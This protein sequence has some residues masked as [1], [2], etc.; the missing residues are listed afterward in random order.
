MNIIGVIIYR[1]SSVISFLIK[2]CSTCNTRDIEF[3]YTVRSP[4]ERAILEQS[5]ESIYSPKDNT[6]ILCL[7]IYKNNNY[8]CYFNV[9]VQIMQLDIIF[10][11]FIRKHEYDIK[12]QPVSYTIKNIFEKLTNK[13]VVDFKENVEFLSKVPRLSQLIKLDTGGSITKCYKKLMDIIQEENFQPEKVDFFIR[14]KIKNNVFIKCRRC[15]T[16]QII[17]FYKNTLNIPY[18]TFLEDALHEQNIEKLIKELEKQTCAQCKR[19]LDTRSFRLECTLPEILI[20]TRTKILST[21]LFK[22]RK[23]NKYPIPYY[24][25]IGKKKYSLCGIIIY[26]IRFKSLHVYSLLKKRDSWYHYDDFY[27]SRVNLENFFADKIQK[28]FDFFSHFIFRLSNEWDQ[29]D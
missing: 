8:I 11:E 13:S 12:I 6:G 15:R 24:L 25:N 29:D 16:V 17:D 5:Y 21:I 2:P 9:I 1:L 22:K 26:S 23:I 20:I 3:N 19:G 27:T 7:R 18:K 28:R 10:V 14:Y 4:E